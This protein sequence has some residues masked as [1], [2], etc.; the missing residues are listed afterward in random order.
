MV[1]LVAH[2]SLVL[3]SR[4]SRLTALLLRP[5]GA[6]G[7]FGG[8]WPPCGWCFWQV[9][10]LEGVPPFLRSLWV[11]RA[12]RKPLRWPRSY[13]LAAGEYNRFLS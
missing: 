13:D 9:F 6:P 7:V 1:V 11:L 10:G 4:R 5:T 12:K 2:R 8:A 3:Q